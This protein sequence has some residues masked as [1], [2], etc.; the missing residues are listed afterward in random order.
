MSA[1]RLLSG[2]LV[3]LAMAVLIYTFTAD[4]NVIHPHLF[5]RVAAG[6]FLLALVVD[7]VVETGK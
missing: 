1:I 4:W 5:S 7:R 2:R 3:I 6:I